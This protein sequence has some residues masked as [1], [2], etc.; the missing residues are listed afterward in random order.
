MLECVDNFNRQYIYIYPDR[1]P[2]LLVP[3]NECDIKV[4]LRICAYPL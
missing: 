2:L 1:K 3:F 4:T